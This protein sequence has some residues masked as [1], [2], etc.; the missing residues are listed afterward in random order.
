MRDFFILLQRN[1]T[2]QFPFYRSVQV[3]LNP[4]HIGLKY[5]LDM[6]GDWRGVY[7]QVLIKNVLLSNHAWLSFYLLRASNCWTRRDRSRSW[8][9]TSTARSGPSSTHSRS[10][11]GAAARDAD[12]GKI[13][14]Q[15]PLWTSGPPDPKFTKFHQ[16]YLL[17]NLNKGCVK[18]CKN[19]L[20]L[21]TISFLQF[22]SIWS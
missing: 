21:L 13:W 20:T 8:S 15:D 6:L 1:Y 2:A 5:S 12:P 9:P 22:W 4:N 19:I 17:K 7:M 3:I 14:I 11:R 18:I 10:S 16:K